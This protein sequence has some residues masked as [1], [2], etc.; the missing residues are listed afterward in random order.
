MHGEENVRPGGLRPAARRD[1]GIHPDLEWLSEC[2]GQVEQEW[3]GRGVGQDRTKL[4]GKRKDLVVSSTPKSLQR[5]RE[6]TKTLN[7][8]QQSFV[9]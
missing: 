6:D 7:Q 4:A 1:A 5:I 2:L 3:L 9:Q 8:V